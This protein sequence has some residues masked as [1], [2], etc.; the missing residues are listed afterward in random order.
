MIPFLNS[1]YFF[2]VAEVVASFLWIAR[3]KEIGVM[4]FHESLLGNLAMSTHSGGVKHP[5]S[6]VL[7]KFGFFVVTMNQLEHSKKNPSVPRTMEVLRSFV[8]RDIMS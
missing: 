6:G 4:K 1:Q 7:M 3:F 2:L 5:I 8:F